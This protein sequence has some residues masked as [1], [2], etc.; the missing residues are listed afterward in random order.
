[1]P[2]NSGEHVDRTIAGGYKYG[3]K[4]ID[5]IRL[6]NFLALLSRYSQAEIARRM[7]RGPAQ[8]QQWA[9]KAQGRD[10]KGSR[11][12]NDESAR[13]IEK[14][15]GLA[16][17][18]MDHDHSGPEAASNLSAPTSISEWDG[19]DELENGVVT[20][21]RYRMGISAGTGAVLFE[22]E[23][24]EAGDAFRSSWLRSV[25]CSPKDCFMA[26][27]DGDSMEPTLADGDSVLISRAQT[28]IID[29]KIYALAYD[30][31]IYCKR[32]FKAGGELVLRSDNPAYPEIRAPIGQIQIIGR[33]VWAAKVL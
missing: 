27:V 32:L 29:R 1:M 17:N 5:E 10:A 33:V 19:P 18:W 23:Q 20:I 4:P 14:A 3:M 7:G 11:N 25:G 31:K 21:P 26:K 16:A 30:G 28:T 8:V 15:L 2:V 12:I 9:A 22:V 24:R 6:S 13:L